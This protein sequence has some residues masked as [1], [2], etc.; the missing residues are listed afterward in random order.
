MQAEVDTAIHVTD[1]TEG[2]EVARILV[3]LRAHPGA[4]DVV[5]G[6]EVLP[7]ASHDDDTYLAVFLGGR[8]GF[9]EL[10]VD[11]AAD[12]VHH[13]G[14]V[15]G[16]GRDVVLARETD[17]LHGRHLNLSWLRAGLPALVSSCCRQGR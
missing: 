16:D 17:I 5:S 1:A 4:A 11:L 10:R 9:V 6:T 13:L 14:S 7:D 15:D 8:E 2:G 12:G 3:E